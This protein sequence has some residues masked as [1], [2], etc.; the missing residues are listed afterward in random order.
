MMATE[1]F[2]L[3][4]HGPAPE[5]PREAL[6]WLA[7]QARKLGPFFGGSFRPPAEGVYFDTL[8]PSTGEPLAAVAQGSAAD[9]DAAVKTAPRAPAQR[10]SLTPHPPARH[11]YT[12]APQG[13]KHFPRACGPPHIPT[14][15]PPPANP[16]P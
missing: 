9:I 6:V 8:D 1:K 14:T 2:V 11:L 15:Q 16:H 10:Q 3:M 12:P 5:D 13:Q 4:Q 7:Q